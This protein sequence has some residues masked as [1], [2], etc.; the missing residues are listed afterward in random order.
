MFGTGT[1]RTSPEKNSPVCNLHNQSG[2]AAL[3]GG[4][5]NVRPNVKS[6]VGSSIICGVGCNDDLGGRHPTYIFQTLVFH[7]R[8][9]EVRQG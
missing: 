9:G 8:G 1:G 4:T 6:V 2:F 3:L 5:Y 7:G